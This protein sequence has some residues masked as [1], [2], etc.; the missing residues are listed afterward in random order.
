MN[1][2][3]SFWGATSFYNARFK[4][5]VL[6]ENTDFVGELSLSKARYNKLFI[7]WYN[8]TSGLVYDDAAY[9]SLMKN[10]KDLGYYEDI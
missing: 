6:F 1:R 9:M 7:R 4:E 8:I 10:F 3:R 2:M 5:N